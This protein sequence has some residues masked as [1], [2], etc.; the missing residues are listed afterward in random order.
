MNKLL[1]KI[2]AFGVGVAMA[3]GVGV[4]IA[5]SDRNINVAKAES[6][7]YK[8]ALFGSSYN[9]ESISSYT[10]TWYATN[11]DFRV[12]ITNFNNN[13]NGWNYI[14]AGRKGYA[15]VG[16]ITTNSSIDKKIEKIVV[17]VDGVTANKINSQKLYVASNSTFTSDLQTI[18][19]SIKSGNNVFTIPSPVE[20]SF[21]KL[22]WDCASGSSN[23]LVTVSKIEYF[24]VEEQ[25]QNKLATPQ[26][27]F[28]S[29]NKQVTWADI[30]H[31]DSYTVSID[32]GDAVAATSP[33]SVAGLSH[34]AA[35]TVSVIAIS[36]DASYLDS[37]AGL[38]SFT[39]FNH[40]GT[41]ADPYNIDDA[42]AAIDGDYGTT[43]V[44]VSGIVSGIVTEYSSQYHNISYNISE[45]GTTTG[46]QLQAFRGRGIDDSDFT[47]ENDILAG[48]KVVIFGSLKK[49]N[50]TYEFDAGNYLVYHLREVAV[51]SIALSGVGVISN[52]LE[53]GSD[54]TDAHSITVTINA[55]ATD[56][57]I[58]IAHLSGTN[59]LFTLGGLTSG[60][61]TCNDSGVGTFTLT[62]TEAGEGSET[63]KV[64]S[65]SNPDV[66]VNLVVTAIDQSVTYY[67]VTYNANGG[68]VS[69]E[70]ESIENGGHPSLPTPTREHYS[71][72]GWK[73]NGEGEYV[74]ASYEVLGDVTLVADW[75]ED[76]KYSVTYTAGDNGSGSYEHANQYVGNYTLLAFTDL[77]G[78][79]ANTGYQFKDYTVVIAGNPTTK[80]PGETI[81][82]QKAESIT[83]NFEE[84]PTVIT[85]NFPTIASAEGWENSKP[86]TTV[87]SDPIT[88]TAQG[89]GN[90]GKWYETSGG[91]WRMYSGGTVVITAADGY[92]VTSVTSNPSCEFTITDGVASFSPSAR[93]DFV[94]INVNYAS[95][96]GSGDIPLTGITFTNVVDNE[97]EIG[98]NGQFQLE[99]E[100]TP[101][102]A[103]D[104]EVKFTVEDPTAGIE[105]DENGLIS[106]G[107]TLD[108]TT[109]VK[110]ESAN[111]ASIYD[112][113]MVTIVLEEMQYEVNESGSGSALEPVTTVQAGDQAYMVVDT[114]SEKREFSGLST[115]STVYGLG[116]VYTTDIAKLQLLTV[117]EGASEGTISF[118]MSDGKYL[119]WNS[120]N[121]LNSKSDKDANSSWT[122]EDGIITNVADSARQIWWNNGSPRFAC[123]T[124]KTTETAGYFAP[125]FLKVNGGSYMLDVDRALFDAVVGNFG[126]GKVYEWSAACATFDAESWEL[127]CGEITGL[128]NFDDYKLNRAV[129]NAEGNEIEQFLAKYDVIVAKFKD[130]DYDFLGR[131]EEDGINHA[132]RIVNPVSSIVS[133]NGS[134]IIIVVVS[135][136]GVSAIGG[137]LF[138]RKRKENQ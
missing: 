114:G 71:F 107:S 124:G 10:S 97:L 45:D 63:F 28:D 13:K 68:Q 105:V 100:Y 115:T 23:G 47:S 112:E 125:S 39:L 12:D 32:G 126:E 108:A 72:N 38:I 131:F 79:S 62:G 4:A 88:I 50:S 135:L 75:T 74:T 37:S 34:S 33:Y 90:N 16:T 5:N 61:I 102:D 137:Y 6:A 26:P 99:W 138:L 127:A 58:N 22:E 3:A 41:S 113:V 92:E 25:P 64:S 85:F 73:V 87:I 31:A 70:S 1:T 94:E 84:K 78:V 66:S 54:D 65:N 134:A 122:I 117:E 121:S 30:D 35:H 69:V 14:K 109:F 111:D 27:V 51:S 9:S 101:S 83:V 49:Y 29:A 93:T 106:V 91:S 103:T 40:A 96:G 21:Y 20:N 48:D 110:I 89:G 52:S 17:T 18:T 123:Y 43:N 77:S 116:E 80:N 98:R 57:Q 67:T 86:Y 19:V 59:G 44:Y 76:A 136:L 132:A 7:V 15:S 130:K 11:D 81:D 119:S 95:K 53:I 82:L 56:K 55:D 36:N 104:K 60:H 8:T 128:D 118:A 120:G 129:A 24:A 42:F 46:N 133:S 2:A